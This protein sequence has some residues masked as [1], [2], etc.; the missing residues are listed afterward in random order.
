MKRPGSE[1]ASQPPPL[2]HHPQSV[3]SSS[4]DITM[5]KIEKSEEPDFGVSIVIGA[6][7]IVP[8][9]VIIIIVVFLRV[10]KRCKYDLFR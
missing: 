6:L 7:L 3:D 9:L 8:V 4:D 5:E 2:P 1:S 10:R